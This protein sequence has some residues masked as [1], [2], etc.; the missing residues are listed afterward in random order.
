MGE[1]PLAKFSLD[2]ISP[3]LTSLDLNIGKK[4]WRIPEGLSLSGMFSRILSQKKRKIPRT[5]KRKRIRTKR[6][7]TKR[8]VTKKMTK[9]TKRRTKRT[10]RKSRLLLTAHSPKNEMILLLKK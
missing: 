10:K 3:K 1:I 5:R 7:V 2:G 6:T 4:F 8:M 9:R